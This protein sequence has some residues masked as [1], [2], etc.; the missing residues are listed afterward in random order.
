MAHFTGLGLAPIYPC[1]LHETP[2]RFGK[3]NAS[4]LMGYQMAVAY[5]GST[6]MPPFLGFL[7][8]FSTIGIFPL[9]LVVSAAALLLFSEW[10]NVV[11]RKRKELRQ[12]RAIS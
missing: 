5:T 12:I 4:T 10:L 8:G 1:M 3:T 7:A 11:L 2:I 9:Y 6:L